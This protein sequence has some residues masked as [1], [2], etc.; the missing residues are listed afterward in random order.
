MSSGIS[1][2]FRLFGPTLGFLLG[3]ACLKIYVN[4]LLTPTIDNKNANWIGAWWLG[5]ILLGFLMLCITFVIALF[6]RELPRKNNGSKI[7][8]KDAKRFAGENMVKL[9]GAYIKLFCSQIS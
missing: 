8:P 1:S 2:A 5:W 7:S 4:P 9:T 6:P 3:A